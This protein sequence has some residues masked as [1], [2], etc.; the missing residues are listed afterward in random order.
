MPG[1]KNVAVHV[2]HRVTLDPI[3]L[4][5]SVLCLGPSALGGLILF[6]GSND[7]PEIL[8]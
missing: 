7:G 3:H 8:I 5:V 2:V 4:K 6:A 1:R